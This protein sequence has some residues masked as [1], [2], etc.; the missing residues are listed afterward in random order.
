[1]TCD[2]AIF[3]RLMTRMRPSGDRGSHPGFRRAKLEGERASFLLPFWLFFFCFFSC[4]KRAKLV[5][6]SST[7]LV[8]KRLVRSLNGH[9]NIISLILGELGGVS[10][11]L[12]KLKSNDFLLKVFGQNI[13][14][15]LI[16]ADCLFHSQF[17]LGNH[18]VIY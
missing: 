16:L 18:L 7:K 4:S 15:L 14:L 2:Q 8:V 17:K 6:T 9:A 12:A 1:M 5:A 10:S 13:Q 3:G 11:K